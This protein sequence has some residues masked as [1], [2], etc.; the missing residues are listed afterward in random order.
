MEIWA[1]KSQ[2][3]NCHPDRKTCRNGKN[4][5]WPT[6]R[7]VLN[8]VLSICPTVK[9]YSSPWHDTLCGT[10]PRFWHSWSEYHSL[11]AALTVEFGSWSLTPYWKPHVGHHGNSLQPTTV[12]VL[13]KDHSPGK[14]L[15]YFYI[16]TTW[17]SIYTA[18]AGGGGR[19]S[20][21]TS[22][23]HYSILATVLL[24]STEFYWSYYITMWVTAHSMSLKHSSIISS[25]QTLY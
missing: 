24:E 16:K 1:A 17:C 18:A 4:A 23:L 14:T 12:G 19:K 10:S 5:A 21:W 9:Y 15:R 20:Y 25:H 11:E 22:I 8:V 13:K 6:F 3:L 7:Y 2:K